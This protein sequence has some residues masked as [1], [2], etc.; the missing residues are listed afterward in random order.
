MRRDI[1]IKS[2]PGTSASAVKA[3]T[4]ILIT[5]YALAAIVGKRLNCGRNLHAVTQ[6]PDTAMF[7]KAEL[8]RPP[9]GSQRGFQPEALSRKLNPFD[10]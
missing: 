1:R 3:Q 5:V 9:N 2:L 4:W 10:L 7:E 8:N 6:I